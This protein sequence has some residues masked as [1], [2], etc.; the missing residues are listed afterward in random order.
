MSRF[1][2]SVWCTVGLGATALWLDAP[3]LLATALAGFLSLL[4][5]G[6]AIPRWQWFGPFRCHGPRTAR[7]VALTFDDGPDPSATPALLELLARERVPA[8]FFVIGARAAAAPQ[9]TAAIAAAGHLLG[10]HSYAH[11]NLTN[12]YSTGR[13]AAEIERA[14]QAIAAASG[15]APRYFR[16]PIGLSNPNTFAAARRL[17]LEVVGWDVRSLDTRSKDPAAIVRR[18]AQRLRPGS[19]VLLHD[20]GIPAS[21][22]CKTVHLLLQKLR[23]LDYTVVRLDR[24]L[25]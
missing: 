18:V 13:L 7:E 23:E 17:G 11:G 15:V 14:Q 12:F 19:V 20:G 5:L 21:Q 2:L 24:L 3:W 4:G 8:A 1:H 10:N 9:L 16:P 25:P 22:L 6:V